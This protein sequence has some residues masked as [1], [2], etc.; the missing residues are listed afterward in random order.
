MMV[1]Q[2]TNGIKI[3]VVSNFEGTN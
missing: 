1:Q 3:S 2:V